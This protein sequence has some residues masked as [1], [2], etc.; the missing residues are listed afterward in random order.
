MREIIKQTV[1]RISG[2]QVGFLFFLVLE[3]ST[4]KLAILTFNPGVVTVWNWCKGQV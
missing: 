2:T 1:N 3:L 4:P